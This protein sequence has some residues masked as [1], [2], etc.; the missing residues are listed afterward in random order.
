MTHEE[1]NAAY[2][3]ID[4]RDDTDGFAPGY[5]AEEKAQIAGGPNA[6]REPERDEDGLTAE[7]WARAEAEMDAAAACPDYDEEAARGADDARREAD[8]EKSAAAG[9]FKPFEASAATQ[10][11]AFVFE[12]GDEENQR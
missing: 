4:Q 5:D 7:D 9:T 12:K 1:N 10:K 3:D 2:Q 8:H 11:P 6:E